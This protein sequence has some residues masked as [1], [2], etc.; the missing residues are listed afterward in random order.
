[1][2]AVQSPLAAAQAGGL[3]LAI[4]NIVPQMQTTYRYVSIPMQAEATAL[5]C[6]TATSG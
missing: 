2:L 5:Q 1:M 3:Q 6:V 4:T